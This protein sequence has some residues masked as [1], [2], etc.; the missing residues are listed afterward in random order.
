M[1][2]HGVPAVAF[3]AEFCS[4]AAGLDDVGAG[5]ERAVTEYAARAVLTCEAMAISDILR[6]A[7]ASDE[8]LSACASR[9]SFHHGVLLSASLP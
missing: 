7:A 6:F 8:E 1:I 9:L 2:G 4:S 5:L 3:P